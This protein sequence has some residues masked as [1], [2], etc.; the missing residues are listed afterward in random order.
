MK[1]ILLVVTLAF[2][3]SSCAALTRYKCNREYAAKKGMDDANNGLSSMP[4]KLDGS[5]CE[6]DYS[7]SS[8]AKDYDYGFHQ[9]KAE[10]CQ[11]ANAA[12]AGKTDGDLGNSQKPQKAKFQL[13]QDSRNFA[14]FESTYEAEFQKA[15]CSAS[16]AAKAA[17]SQAQSWQAPNFDELFASC[18]NGKALLRT[19][20]DSYK[21]KMS[22]NCSLAEAS[23][24]GEEEAKANRPVSDGL[25]KMKK[26]EAT[27]KG[28]FTS[29][30]ES[31][32]VAMKS[33]LDSEQKQREALEQER[34]RQI[35]TQEFLS[36]VATTHFLFA[37]K[38]MIA[39]CSVA[40]DRSFV[41]AE[42]ENRYP[43]QVLIQGRWRIQ[44]YGQDFQKI[45]E[46][47]TTEAI[48]ITP[49]NKKTFQKMT[50]PRDA[51]YCRAEFLGA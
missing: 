22:E 1:N 13:C 31:A 37:T 33:R 19:Y 51:A 18:G 26:C 12:A 25:E 38:S 15:F 17:E 2:T 23:R 36:N 20:Q 16:R 44:Y 42:V 29:A 8:F 35:R 11:L 10:I 30:F 34:L 14:K 47:Q 4:G 50:L 27:G 28:N 45:T 43:D 40:P 9:K 21:R 41:Q 48:L 3:F 5:S 24:F 49:Q 7:P 32:Y 39:R 46:D 6:G